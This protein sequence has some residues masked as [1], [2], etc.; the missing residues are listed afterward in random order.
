MS[1][2]VCIVRIAGYGP[3]TLELGSD[4]E[5]RLQSLQATLYAS[6]Q[7]AFSARGALV[8]QNRSDELFALT[9]GMSVADHDAAIG[10]VSPRFADIDLRAA[11]G[12][13]AGALDANRAAHGASLAA[14]QDAR[15]CGE[16]CADGG[17]G[18]TILHM[19]VDGLSARRRESSPYEITSSIY[20]LYA[21]MS[22]FFMSRGA[23]SFFMGGD[24]F[25]VVTGAD[26]EKVRSDAQDFVDVSRRLGLGLNCGIGRGSTARKAASA[27][28]RSLD[29][30]RC[31]RK[32]GKTD[33]VYEA[34]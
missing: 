34:P 3:W 13:A 10:E 8:F 16:T 15:V 32:D 19:D 17:G 28:T 5:H 7:D 9:N 20:S 27:A 2:Q 25:M 12:C 4:R 22:K 6:L 29:E 31:M 24:N 23:M 33:S 21:E 1:V 11:I 18:L 30:I 14:P 26:I